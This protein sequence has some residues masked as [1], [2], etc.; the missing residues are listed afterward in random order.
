MFIFGAFISARAAAVFN[1]APAISKSRF[2]TLSFSFPKLP[3]P[4]LSKTGVEP[5]EA[6]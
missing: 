4:S 6:I 1:I 3:L 2:F 5:P